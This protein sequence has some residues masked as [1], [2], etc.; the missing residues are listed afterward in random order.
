[1]D[2]N[3][4]HDQHTLSSNAPVLYNLSFQ[5]FLQLENKGD[6]PAVGMWLVIAVTMEPTVKNAPHGQE[7][8]ME[9]SEM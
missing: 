9:R 4:W 8:R 2:R 3:S 7:Q 5:G 6:I 1:L